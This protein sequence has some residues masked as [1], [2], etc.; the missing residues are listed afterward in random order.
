MF[1]GRVKD[2]TKALNG[3]WNITITTRYDFREEFDFLSKV[4]CDIEIVK[5]REI[6]SKQANAYFHVLVNKIAAKTG[7]GDDDIKRS[8]VIKYG[9][10]AKDS[11]GKP[12]GFMAPYGKSTGS[13][14][15]YV[16]MF[17]QRDINGKLFNCYLCYKDTH[18]M[19]TAEMARLI[20]GA[21]D[22]AKEL[23]I[24]TETPE[25]LQ[26]M[27]E[28]WAAYETAHPRKADDPDG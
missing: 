22:E 10:I 23:G 27:K 8:L 28:Q 4:D 9:A 3:E 25:Q 1:Q 26:R 19:D 21:I 7:G 5:H 20:D 15:K 24:Q 13:V 11:D 16:R 2:M 6:R 17:D 12:V 14:W 18:Q